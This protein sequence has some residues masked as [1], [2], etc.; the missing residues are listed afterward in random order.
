MVKFINPIIITIISIGIVFICTLI[1]TSF[2]FFIK[3]KDKMTNGLFFGLAGGIMIASG[4]FGLLVPGMEDAK[5]NFKNI[6]VIFVTI[7]FLLGGL[8]IYLIDKIVIAFNKNS[9]NLSTNIKLVT[10]IA[11]HNVPE[12]L[13]VGFA[14]GL[15][16]IKKDPESIMSALTFAIGIAIQNIPEGS[17]VS[18]PLYESGVS[19]FKAF[20]AGII[21][22]IIEPIFALI[23]IM[24]VT[25]SKNLLS[26]FLVFASG[27]M[28]Y[29]TIDELLPRIK[30]GKN[31]YYG[32]F[33]FMIGFV[34][35][36][37][38]ELIL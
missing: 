6:S 25:S 28:I 26:L 11:I 18:I 34:I 36:L 27:S 7:S 29:V 10:A 33:A 4:I 3:K 12:G 16:L 30:E 20:I 22:G 38:L 5:D 14:C 21:S 19:K 15:A 23:G 32:L 1:G 31:E 8:L 2:I 24:L 13:A 9:P 17:V 35:M 37:I